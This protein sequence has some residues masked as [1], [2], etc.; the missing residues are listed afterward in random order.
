MALC[1][2][3]YQVEKPRDQIAGLS[4]PQGPGFALRGLIAL[5]QL[6]L[7]DREMQYLLRSKNCADAAEY[8]T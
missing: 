3:P 1:R 8:Q 6:K 5:A 7:G 2:C 4:L